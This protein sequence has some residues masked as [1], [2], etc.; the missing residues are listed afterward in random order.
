MR[1]VVVGGSDAGI[2]AGLRARAIDPT[3]DIHVV[4]GDDYPNFSIC[5]LP[6]WISRDVPDWRS[7]AHRTIDDLRAS[8]LELT[9]GMRAEAL[10]AHAR[11]LRCSTQHSTVTVAY[12]RLIVATG[13]EPIVP[14]LPG[15]DL[16]GV[17]LLHHMA[18]AFA[19][20][21]ALDRREVRSTLIVGAGYIGL[22]MAEALRSRGLGVTVVEQLPEVL[23]TVDPDLGERVR[24]ELNAHGVA[25]RVGTSV[26]AIEAHGHGLRV[27]TDD[28]THVVDAVLVCVG[29]RPNARLA[30]DAGAAEGVRGTVRVDEAMATS[31]PD[32]WAAGDCVHTHHRL[33]PE[34]AY[35]PLGTTAHKQGRVA[36]ENAAGGRRRF[37]GSVGTQVVKVFDLAIARTGL[38]D[39][40]ARAAGFEPVTVAAEA[41]DHKRYYRGAHELAMRW[42]ADAHSGRVLGCQILG[43]RDGQVAKRIDVVA[44]AVFAGL[45]IDEISDLDLSY[46]PPFGSPWDALQVGAQRWQGTRF[47]AKHA[48]DQ[49]HVAP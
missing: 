19:L 32:V 7:L 17:H 44:T 13:A 8:G 40:E 48:L 5:G 42:T 12:D 2:A 47:S 18:D 1:L 30:L 49:E 6:Y 37:A 16:P 15:V 34:P 4:V 45:T 31:L 39:Q 14:S 3:L 10:D 24:G 38:R 33:L 21:A 43:H 28:G 20:D 46:T 29:V 41:D 25:V 23:A 27:L 36:G 35:L 26:R 22:E 11:K 9:L